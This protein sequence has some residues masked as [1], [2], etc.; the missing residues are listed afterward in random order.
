MNVEEIDEVANVAT[1]FFL[2]TSL[3]IIMLFRLWELQSNPEVLLC[4][5]LLYGT[6]VTIWFVLHHCG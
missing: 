1:V 6:V 5:L 3:D 4:N 2:S